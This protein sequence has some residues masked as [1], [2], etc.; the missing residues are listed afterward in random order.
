[1]IIFLTAVFIKK[2]SLCKMSYFLEPYTPNKNKT[3]FELVF[4][5]YAT[6]SDL[7]MQQVLIH[8]IL[9]KRLI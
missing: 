4:S 2:V 7:K 8:Q 6:K 1:M 9:L 3:K 5:N